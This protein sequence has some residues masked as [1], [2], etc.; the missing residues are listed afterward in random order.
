MDDIHDR[1]RSNIESN[2]KKDHP[3]DG[4]QKETFQVNEVAWEVHTWFWRGRIKRNQ[5]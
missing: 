5:K 2:S 4:A 1:V 3:H